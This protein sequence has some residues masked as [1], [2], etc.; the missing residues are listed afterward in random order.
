MRSKNKA[1][2]S[3]LNKNAVPMDSSYCV[4]VIEQDETNEYNL[5]NQQVKIISFPYM[6]K[7]IRA[8]GKEKNKRLRTVEFILVEFENE[9][10]R[11]VNM[12]KEISKN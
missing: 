4:K 7:F 5:V 3:D 9:V 12:F 10:Y 6:R 11:V 2:P 8:T 1:K